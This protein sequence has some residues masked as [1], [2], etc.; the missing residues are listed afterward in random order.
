M[1]GVMSDKIIHT[2]VSLAFGFAVAFI[3]WSGL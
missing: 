2:I 3:L 1:V